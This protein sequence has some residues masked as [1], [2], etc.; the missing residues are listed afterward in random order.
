MRAAMFSAEV[1]D[2]V[3]NVS[4][5]FSP[6][7]VWSK[8]DATLEKQEDPTVNRLQERVAEL[9]GHEAGLFCVSAT[10]ANQLAARTHL[11]APPYSSIC[12]ARSH[13]FNYE[14]SGIAF[15]CGTIH[16]NWNNTH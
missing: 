13:V 5:G 6:F 4:V 3:Y 8:L 15:H 11:K 2:D 1:G 7:R 9:T 16:R 12:D 14:A 10:M